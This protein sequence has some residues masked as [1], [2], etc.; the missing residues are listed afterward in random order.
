MVKEG[1]TIVDIGITRVDADNKKG[2]VL[3]GDVD[4]EA[5]KGKSGA[6]T[7]VPG[8]VGPMTRYGLLHNTLKSFKKKYD[9]A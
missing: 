1:A 5:V 4:Y 9:I 2:Y 8:G 7:P 3:K 6:I